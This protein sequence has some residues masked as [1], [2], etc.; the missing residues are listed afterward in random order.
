MSLYFIL[1]VFLQIH[2]VVAALLPVYYNNL[3]AKLCISDVLE[4]VNIKVF[5]LLSKT[6]ETCNLSSHE[7]CAF[8]FRL[9][10]SVYNDRQR[11]NS[12]KNR[13]E[14]KELINKGWG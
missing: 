13:C 5:N 4:I 3:H 6:N 7:T 11:W 9:D 14:C 1:S 10:A 2:V 8:K 12:Y